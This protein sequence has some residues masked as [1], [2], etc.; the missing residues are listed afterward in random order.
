MNNTYYYKNKDEV[1]RKSRE[2]RKLLMKDPAYVEKIRKYQKEYYL[3]TKSIKINCVVCNRTFV[4]RGLNYHLKS[5]IHQQNLFLEQNPH[6]YNANIEQKN[7]IETI[8]NKTKKVYKR[9]INNVKEYRQRKRL[10][11]RLY[12][13]KQ[14]IKNIKPID[15]NKPF[16]NKIIIYG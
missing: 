5:K 11:N 2:R 16:D 7:N 9:K 15:K 14:K 10:Y 12:K 13:R 4:G 6:A 8:K 1:L 3:K